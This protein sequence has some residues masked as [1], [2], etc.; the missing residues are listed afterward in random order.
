MTLLDD[1]RL[2]KSVI[3]ATLNLFEGSPPSSSPSGP[4][5][6]RALEPRRGLVEGLC[7]GFR[8]SREARLVCP[9]SKGNV[10]SS[11]S[12]GPGQLVLKRIARHSTSARSMMTDNDSVG[13]RTRQRFV[14]GCSSHHHQRNL[15]KILM[16]FCHSPSSFFAR[17]R[18]GPDRK[19]ASQA[20]GAD[21]SWPPG[22]C[23]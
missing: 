1:L 23:P 22:V 5:A 11:A 20:H 8:A 4:G 17:H 12:S 18:A 14:K 3:V 9:L 2:F 13:A 6:I 16:H 7:D 15:L 19:D 10:A 21:T